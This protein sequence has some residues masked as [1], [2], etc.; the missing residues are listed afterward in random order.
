M[1]YLTVWGCI[2]GDH[3]YLTPAEPGIPPYIGKL[4]SLHEDTAGGSMCATVRWYYRLVLLA[5][6][7]LSLKHAARKLVLE[8][9]TTA[10]ELVLESTLGI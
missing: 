8:K 1:K 7:C 10:R 6:F 5:M 3:I 2:A 9:S 4:H